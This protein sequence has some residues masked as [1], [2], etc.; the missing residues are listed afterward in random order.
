[1]ILLKFAT[2][3]KG[4]STVASH[5]DWITVDSLQMGVGRS[6][7]T[8]GVGKDRD[9]SNPSF[10]E[11][12]LTKSMD[13]ASVD[14]WMQSICGKSLGT[15]T[16]HFIQTG[17]A[18][19]KG[20]VYLEIELADAIISGYSQSSGGDRPHESISINFN[21]IKMKYNTFGEGEAPAAGAFK[22]WN[23]MKNETV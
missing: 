12:T 10:S 5:T 7:S 21:E 9:T 20:Q 15:A 17:G 8:S 19:A 1:M 23:L 11:V 16:F 4:D 18:D 22:G 3:I 6:I 13:I 2:E 14:L